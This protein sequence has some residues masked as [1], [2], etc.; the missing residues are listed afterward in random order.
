MNLADINNKNQTQL[1]GYANTLNE[2]SNLYIQKK[3]PRKI[4]L[5]GPNGIGKSTF[6][7]HLINYIFSLNEKNNYD[8]KNLKINETNRSF[9]LVKKNCHPNFHLIEL[10]DEKKIIEIDQIRKMINFCNKSS[11]NNCEKIVLI[12]NIEKLNKNS[13]NA[14][15]KI[16]EEQNNNIYFILILDSNKK[17][18]N[19]LKSRCIKFNLFLTSKKSIE[20]ANLITNTN[21]SEMINQDLLHYYSSPGHYINLINFSKKYDF[22]LKNTNLKKF[23]IYLID[24]SYYTKDNFISICIYQYLE[25][26]LLKITN[27]NNSKM[28]N[29][30]YKKFIQ[31]IFNMH[32]YNLDKESFFI[33]VRSK[34]FYG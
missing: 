8:L 24:N 25:F 22:D 29:L 1:Y 19:T 14:L 34:I 13:V 31:K 27:R 32:K 18:L 3:L 2:L 21:I 23:L 16:V 17:I 9:N 30:L 28:L 26:Y 7:Y 11:F 5:S 6:S 12:D 10:G 20:I 33:E 4:L 15:L